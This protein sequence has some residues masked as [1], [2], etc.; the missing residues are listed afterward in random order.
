MVVAGFGLASGEGASGDE[1]TV[2][3]VIGRGGE[4]AALDATL[5]LGETMDE[6]TVVT[7]VVVVVVLEEDDDEVVVVVTFNCLFLIWTES[8]PLRRCRKTPSDS[9]SSNG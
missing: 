1:S 7:L 9:S 8:V 2:V 3:V 5:P 4:L 6:A